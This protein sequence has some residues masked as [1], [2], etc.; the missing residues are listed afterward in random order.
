M[1]AWW[2]RMRESA[3]VARVL[4]AENEELRVQN[5]SLQRRLAGQTEALEVL[6]VCVGRLN[7]IH[8]KY[9]EA[10]S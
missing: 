1:L 2:R 5:A 8:A 6:N 9:E 4:E 10:T 3:E 7:E